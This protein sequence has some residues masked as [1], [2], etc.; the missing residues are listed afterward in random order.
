[1]P[2]G[3]VAV[4]GGFATVN[5]M[6]VN[7]LARFT[8]APCPADFNNDCFLSFEDADA[9]IDAFV[10]GDPGADFDADGMLTWADVDA[11]IAAFEDGC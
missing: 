7:G 1:M 3:S 11:F 8:Y 9:M 4:S 5:G 10:D 6:P 2:D